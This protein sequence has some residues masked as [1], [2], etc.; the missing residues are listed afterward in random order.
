LINSTPVCLQPF[1]LSKSYH[2]SETVNQEMEQLMLMNKNEN[3]TDNM[4]HDAFNN[5]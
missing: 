3:K 2:L 4:L 1:S 5:A